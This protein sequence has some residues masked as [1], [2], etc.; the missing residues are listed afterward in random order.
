LHIET[1]PKLLLSIS[2]AKDIHGFLTLKLEDVDQKKKMMSARIQLQISK[3]NPVRGIILKH[4]NMKQLE[5][6]NCTDNYT[7]TIMLLAL[8]FLRAH[9]LSPLIVHHQIFPHSYR[10]KLIT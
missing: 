6:E 4:R 5:T 9:Q 7:T 1:T 3:D 2:L 10:F 8:D